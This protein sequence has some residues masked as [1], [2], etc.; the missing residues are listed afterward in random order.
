MVKL[1]DWQEKLK[2]KV[3]EGLRNN[4]LVALNA[5]TG[6]GKTLFSLLVSLEVKPKVL[7][8]VRTHNEFYPIYRDLTKIREKRNITF[9]FLVGKPSSC[10]Y[11]EKGAESEDIPCKY[12]ELKGSI[13]EVK[14]DDSP[15]SLVKK[16]KKDGLQDK[17]CPYYSLL[18]SLYK[19]DVIALTYP[20]FF[21]DRYREFIDIDLREYMI[22]IDEA[23][24]LDKVNEL[25][26]RSLSEITIQ[27][28]I[29]Q[30]KSEES[31]RILSKLLNQL[32]EVVLPDEKYIKVEN[33][34]KLSKEELEIL[35]DDYEDIRKDSLKQGK[36]NKI[37]IGSILRFFSLLSIGS[38]IPFSYS[39]RLVIKN[40]EISYY[41]NLLNDNELSIILMSGTLPP[42]EYME[43]V[44]GIKRNMLYLDVEREIQKRVS[45]SYECYIGVDVTSKYDM[46]SDNMWKRYADYL[47]KIYF[48]AKANVLVVFPSYEIMDRVMSRISLPKYVESEDSSVEDLYSAISANNKVLIGSVGKGKLAEGIEL[49]NNDRSLISDVVIVGIPYPPPDDYLKILAQRVS[50]KMN[51]ENEEFLFKIP[52]LVTIKQ[53][54]GRAIRDVNDKCN[55]WLLD[56]RFESLYWKKNLK[57]LNANKMKL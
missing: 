17:F 40:P 45:G 31:R 4:F 54:I 2:D 10:L 28:A 55:V 26:E 12:C 29:K 38:F 51:R 34:P 7:F 27:M 3:I 9:S 33:V 19:A 22:V 39:K 18:N 30:S 37:H 35:A 48:Q 23:H 24:N 20:Y 49:R 52:A 36:V 11:A 57:C 43:K 6:S 50:L 14:T 42:R 56:K 32:R 5:P 16:L 21:I 1:R 44:W 46:R 47:L 41:L 53:A 8:V 13:V 25:E 15:L